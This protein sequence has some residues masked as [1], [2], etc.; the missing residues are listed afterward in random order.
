MTGLTAVE[1]ESDSVEMKCI[2][3]TWVRIHIKGVLNR[4]HEN[5]SFHSNKLQIFKDRYIII[6]IHPTMIDNRSNIN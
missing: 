4:L 3:K 1:S 6:I 2:V 5:N